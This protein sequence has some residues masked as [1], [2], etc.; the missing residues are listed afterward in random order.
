MVSFFV[1]FAV[2]LT[3]LPQQAAWGAIGIGIITAA[4]FSFI[5]MQAF[6]TK[7]EGIGLLRSLQPLRPIAGRF[8]IVFGSVLAVS[9]LTGLTALHAVVAT[10]PLLVIFQL[11][12]R[13]DTARPIA[14]HFATFLGRSGDELLIISNLYDH[15]RSCRSI[16]YIGRFI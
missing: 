7:G 9:A 3:Y 2:A 1:S 16:R 4:L 10:I 12:R 5:S 8:A 13:G 14:A 11:I 15:R 6:A